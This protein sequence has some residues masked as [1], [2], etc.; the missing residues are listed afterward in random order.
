MSDIIVKSTKHYIFERDTALSSPVVPLQEID[1]VGDRVGMFDRHD[2]L[3]LVRERVV[4]TDGDMASRLVKKPFKGRYYADSADSDTLGTP[5]QTPFG[6]QHIYALTHGIVI[7]H[8][9]AHSHKDHIV[10]ACLIVSLFYGGVDLKELVE[11]IGSGQRA[12]KALLASNAETASHLA[13]Y[14]AGDA[15]GCTVGCGDV[16]RFDEL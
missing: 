2:S 4:K 6:C 3:T 11:D 12:M 9:L 1:N 5:S 7:V 8:R 16:Y 13:T 14:L 15:K 10:N